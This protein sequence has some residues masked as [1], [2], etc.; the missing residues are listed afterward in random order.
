MEGECELPNLRIN[1][2]F[3]R[4]EGGFSWVFFGG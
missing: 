3:D 2:D 4:D 1:L